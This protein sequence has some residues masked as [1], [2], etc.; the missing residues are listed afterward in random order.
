MF[1]NY[2]PFFWARI[3]FRWWQCVHFFFF[4]SLVCT[5]WWPF[6]KLHVLWLLLLKSTGQLFCRMLLSLDVF[7]IFSWLDSGYKFIWQWYYRNDVLF[8]TLHTKV[9][10]VQIYFITNDI[11][12]DHLLKV[13][14]SGFLHSKIPLVGDE[15]IFWKIYF[16]PRKYSASHHTFT[17]KF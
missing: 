14:S 2:C 12:L 10:V 6:L 11:Y 1:N 13:I 5:S 15:L 3:Q 7:D 8:P 16:K 9:Y 4:V 17:Q